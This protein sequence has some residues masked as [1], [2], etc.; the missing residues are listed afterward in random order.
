M[1][2]SLMSSSNRAIP[3][4][5]TPAL[6]SDWFIS[7]SRRVISRFL[8]CQDGVVPSRQINNVNCNIFQA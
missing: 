1:A 6:D 5:H 4:L 2:G 3:A 8:M 7:F